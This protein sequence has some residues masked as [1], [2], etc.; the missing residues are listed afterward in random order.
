VLNCLT[1]PPEPICDPTC[2]L[3]LPANPGAQR[4]SEGVGLGALDVESPAGSYIVFERGGALEPLQADLLI[5]LLLPAA[6]KAGTREEKE[7]PR[8]LYLTGRGPNPVRDAT[9][10]EFGLDRP[11]DVQLAIYDVAGRAVRRL[12]AE[13][14]NAG[15]YARTW[16]GRD[17]QGAVLASGV[18]LAKLTAGRRALTQKVVVAK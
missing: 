12:V 8:E 17:D 16:D 15:V 3:E 2:E 5:D 6:G 4:L 14:L 18:Y 1:C 7:T 10:I 13:R 9:T 11:T